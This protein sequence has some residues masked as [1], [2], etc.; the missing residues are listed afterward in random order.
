MKHTD[1]YPSPTT[2]QIDTYN[3]RLIVRHHYSGAPY[4]TGPRLGSWLAEQERGHQL[5]EALEG[6]TRGLRT[7]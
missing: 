4:Q 5:G 7:N 1:R 6:L 2:E 3:G